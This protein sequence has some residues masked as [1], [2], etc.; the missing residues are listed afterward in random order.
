MA[1]QL[2]RAGEVLTRFKRHRKA[3]WHFRTL[4]FLF[5]WI[6]G[7][8]HVSYPPLKLHIEPTPFCNLRCPMCPQSVPE[9]KAPKQFMELELYRKIIRECQKSVFEVNLFFRGESLFHPNLSEMVRIAEE[10]GVAVNLDTNATVLTGSLSRALI[11]AGLSKIQFSLDG[12]TKELYEKMRK[13]ANFER[14]LDHVLSFLKIKKSLKRRKPHVSIQAI[15]FYKAGEPLRLSPEFRKLFRGLPVNEFNGVWARNW[16]GTF[17]DSPEI[18]ARL[19]K[20]YFQCAWLWKALAV[21]YDG[22]V[23]L[24]CTDFFERHNLGDLKTQSLMEVWNG[25]RM[26]E[27]RRR[28]QKEDYRGLPCEH[29]DFL[30]NQDTPQWRIVHG[31]KNIL[32]RPQKS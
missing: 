11:E 25:P 4:A 8:R 26:Q 21:Y 14:T 15:K 31:M 10:A 29:C 20:K 18:N 3:F 6:R 28:H 5:Q 17:K 32:S 1:F 2:D 30:W 22:T 9:F 16:A 24:C 19:G 13:G 12:E 23:A 7:D 27:M